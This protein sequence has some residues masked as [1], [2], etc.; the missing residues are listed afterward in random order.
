[1]TENFLAIVDFEG[2]QDRGQNCAIIIL[3]TILLLIRQ[4]AASIPL[5]TVY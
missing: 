3:I 1:M 5:H 4:Q 2:T